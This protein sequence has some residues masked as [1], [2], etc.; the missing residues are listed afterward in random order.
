MLIGQREE[1]ADRLRSD[2]PQ[3]LEKPLHDGIEHLVRLQVQRRPGQARVTAVQQIGAKVPDAR[4]R[5]REQFADGGLLT[6]ATARGGEPIQEALH[7]GRRLTLA[8]DV[9]V[10]RAANVHVYRSA[11]VV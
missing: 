3:G 4:D 9:E 2:A 1:L 10:Y 11:A 6:G 5:A 8:H 7:D